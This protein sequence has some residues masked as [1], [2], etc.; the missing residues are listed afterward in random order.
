VQFPGKNALAIVQN[1]PAASIYVSA[2][3][4]QSATHTPGMAASNRV[5]Q[6]QVTVPI[7]SS[8]AGEFNVTVSDF[9]VL[10]TG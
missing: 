4:E 1:F 7:R 5:I 2:P 6:K 10:E 3:R 8:I 9:H